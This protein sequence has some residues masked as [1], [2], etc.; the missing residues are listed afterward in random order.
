MEGFAE[1]GVVNKKLHPH[2]SC[3]PSFGAGENPGLGGWLSPRAVGLGVWGSFGNNVERLGL[4]EEQV[5]RNSTGD[6][7]NYVCD[8]VRNGT[9]RAKRG[10]GDELWRNSPDDDDGG[11]GRAGKQ[12]THNFP[13]ANWTYLLERRPFLLAP[14]TPV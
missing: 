13:P 6:R 8:S 7:G 10:L 5:K 4:G 9:K 3:L 2:P 14:R 1:R 11:L 12:Q